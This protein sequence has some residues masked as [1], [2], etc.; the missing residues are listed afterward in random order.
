MLLFPTDLLVYHSAIYPQWKTFKYGVGGRLDLRLMWDD[1]LH[2]PVVVN[3]VI[4]S[5]KV[6]HGADLHINKWDPLWP[7]G[8]D[9]WLQGLSQDPSY[10]SFGQVVS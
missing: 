2:A 4:L 3:P 8:Y 10:L 5:N 9:A 1:V 6:I 7:D